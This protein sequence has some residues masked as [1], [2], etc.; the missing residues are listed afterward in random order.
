VQSRT[1]VFSKFP[2]AALALVLACSTGLLAADS[3]IVLYSFQGGSDGVAPF[4]ALVADQAGNLYGT[5][6]E[7]GNSNCFED[8]CGTVFELSPSGNGQWAK[9]T[10]YE[11]T[12][13]TDGQSPQ[14]KLA[15]DSAGNVFGTTQFGGD[16]V[17]A[18]GTVFELSPGSDGWTKTTIY[19][20]TKY[21]DLAPK[22]ALT[23]DSAGNLYGT[24]GAARG[25]AEGT[26]FRLTPTKGGQWSEQDL[27][28]FENDEPRGGVV[29]DDAG[30]LYGAGIYLQQCIEAQF[31]GF[32]YELSPATGQW[33]QTV[34]YSFQGGG[35]GWAPSGDLLRYPDG[36][37]Y[38]TATGGGNGLGIAFK[39]AGQTGQWQESMI[40]NFCSLD[41]CADGVFPNGGLIADQAG[42]I[43]GTTYGGLAQICGTVFE[44]E[45]PYLGW[46]YSVLH[47]FVY[48]SSDGCAPY[49][50]LIFGSDGNLY[51]TTSGGGASNNGT[52]FEIVIAKPKA[53]L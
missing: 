53:S 44:M 45:T 34:L 27:Y 38:G 26:V 31:C 14:G 16:P 33:R 35:N 37:F 2:F 18:C 51:G 49:G 3:E 48:Q 23:F 22:S 7:G 15:L 21:A 10:L 46:R 43:Y 17:C 9:K 36:D 4:A 12:G 32:I 28:V 24:T 52:V 5:T 41:S 13:D 11:F 8:G 42:H 25:F 6:R 20:F 1:S 40:Y 39:L 29:L 50:G 47:S 19:A 30:N